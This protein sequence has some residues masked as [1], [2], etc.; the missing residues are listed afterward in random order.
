MFSFPERHENSSLVGI[1]SSTSSQPLI[2]MLIH[3]KPTRHN[4]P[5]GSISLS[6][7]VKTGRGFVGWLLLFTG[8]VTR[9]LKRSAHIMW[10]FMQ[11]AQ[12]MQPVYFI[13]A[14]ACKAAVRRLVNK[15]LFLR[16]SMLCL[17]TGRHMLPTV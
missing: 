17:V 13:Q 4:D 7:V 2:T 1:S 11:G 9:A 10:P 8:I 14:Q 5:S 16:G 12:D 15:I 6:V 3:H